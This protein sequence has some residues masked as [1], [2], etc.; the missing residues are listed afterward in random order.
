MQTKL[1]PPSGRRVNGRWRLER[2]LGEGADATTWAAVDERDGTPVALKALRVLDSEAARERFRWEFAALTR[3]EH[4][5]LVRVFDLDQANDAGALPAGQPFFTA[6][7]LDGTPPADRFAQ[8]PVAARARALCQLLA[9]VGSALVAVH[10]LGLVHHDVKPANLLVDRAGRTRLGDLGLSAAR[11]VSGTIRGTAAYLAPEALTGAGDARVDLFALGA[12]AIALWIGRPPRDGATVGEVLRAVASGAALPPLAGAPAGLAALVAR[13]T[14]QDPAARP[15]SARTVMDEAVRLGAQLDGALLVEPAPAPFVPFTPALVGRDGA[16]RAARAALIEHAPSDGGGARVLLVSGAPGSG[17]SRLVDELRRSEQLAAA[18]AGHAP[19]PWHGPTLAAARRTLLP[20]SSE[21][22]PLG[23]LCARLQAA[24]AVLHLDLGAGVDGHAAELLA[25]AAHGALEPSL[26]VAEVPPGEGEGRGGS[27]LAGAPAGAVVDVRLDALDRAAVAELV[28]SMLGAPAPELGRAVH[29]ASA[30]EPRLCVELVRGAC[31]RARPGEQ[32]TAADLAALDGADLGALL[33]GAMKRLSVEARHAVEALAVLGRGATVGELAALCDAPPPAVLGALRSAAA[34]GL[35]AL[36]AG[37]A[38]FPSRAHA[39]QA[40]A[41]VTP[42][43]RRALHR[44]A[45]AQAEAGG[46]GAAD[47]ARHLAVLGPPAAVAAAWLEAGEQALARDQLEEAAHAFSAALGGG[48]PVVARARLRLCETL[49]RRAEYPAALLAVA[50]L[51][52]SA[53]AA[54]RAQAG[55]AAARALQRAGD[56]AAA[57]AR[58]RP[59]VGASAALDAEVRGLLGRVLLARGAYAE[60]VAVCAGGP[61]SPATDEARGLALLYLGRLDEAAGA[62]ATVAAAAE[63]TPIALARAHSLHGMLAQA[64]D[65]LPEAARADAAALALARGAADLHGAATYAANLGAVLRDQAEY[66]RALEPTAEAARDLGR[67]GKRLDRSS[68][69]FNYGNLLLSLGDLDGA[70]RA[71]DEARA[72]AGPTPDGAGSDA[73]AAPREAGYARLLSADVARRRGR[74]A[75]AVAD[76]EAALASFAPGAIRERL[77]ALGNLAEAHAEAGQPD[78]ARA[79]KDEALALARAHGG[80]GPVCES[81]AR[82]ALEL[83]TTPEPSVIASLLATR[84]HA[85]RT[86]RR[87]V[88]FRADVTLA[89]IHIRSGELRRAAECVTRAAATWKEIVMRTP[90]LRRDAAA[91]DPDAK[92]LREL[93]AASGRPAA[94]VEAPAAGS[95]APWRRLMAINKRLNSELRLPVLLELILDTVIELTSAERGFVLLS[96][97]TGALRVEVARNIDQTSLAS[98]EA[99]FSRSIAEQ[100]AREAAPIVTLDAAGDERFGAALSVSDLKLRSVLAVPLSVKGRVVGCV[101]ADHR[102]RSGAFGDADVALVCDLAEQAGIAIEN[103]R[104]LAENQK[105]RKEIAD[106]N[107]ELESKVASQALELGE[108]HKEVRTSRAA[109]SVRYDYENLVGRTPRMLELFRL[110]DRV[111]DTALPV[112]IYG[113]SGTGKELVARAIHHNGPRRDRPFVSESCAAIPETLLEAALFG[114]VRGAF[115][116]ADAERRGLFEVAS[117]GTLFLDE[118]GEMPASMQ[119]K[120]LRVLQSGEFRR[121][122]GERTLKVDVRVLVASNRDL[123]QMVDEGQFR[124]DLFYRLNVVRVALPPLRERRDDVPLLVEHFLAKHAEASGQPPR[125]IARAALQKL[126]GYRWPGNVRELENEILR[127]AALGG[128][129]L[130]VADL[131]PQVSAGEP[132]AAFDSPNDLA[133]KKRVERLERTLLREALSRAD[134][135][136][137]QAARLLGLS[138]YG[139]QKKLKRYRLS[140]SGGA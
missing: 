21:A 65:D 70:A 95:A 50:P 66:A 46:D 118:V 7:L 82:V 61:S 17:R 51:E 121:V 11:G 83:G 41:T 130:T 56:H 52:A 53:D 128:E 12:T 124:E 136:Q 55:L 72:L 91:E 22:V 97:D 3:L 73:A 63:G 79:R 40:Y 69:L 135:N 81:A 10:R 1:A 54:E 116:G 100:A 35:V 98:G 109:L 75:D 43:R 123:Q 9:E 58:L 39:A 89:R 132:E 77:L 84:A 140:G 92:R 25:L 68:A 27:R 15:S 30:G 49:T 102:L 19:R 26:L 120:L 34:S 93:V 113:E 108:L 112:V 14:A 115:T 8:L 86:A 6:E 64:R 87:A 131:S 71:A 133:L 103:A 38:A 33:D 23:R 90:E 127:A 32:P 44:R 37:L 139:L 67:L 85:A 125:R 29:R 80:E 16:L 42:A 96:D 111:T 5:G 74:F 18:A 99:A 94:P 101:Y 138:R 134:G 20:E 31:A 119:V 107:R 36:D 104:L 88:A 48:A 105:R 2:L 117:G 28:A 47:R 122:G 59:L 62:F 114:H 60:A 57:E 106:L 129:T 78:L 45:L 76:C 4:P 126:V 137:S 24:P 13:L 110:L